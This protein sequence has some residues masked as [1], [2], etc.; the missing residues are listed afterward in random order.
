LATQGSVSSLGI[1]SL[2]VVRGGYG[3]YGTVPDGIR[4]LLSSL[5]PL[6]HLTPT[7]R[8]LEIAC[9]SLTPEMYTSIRSNVTGVH[10]L[11]FGGCLDR[12]LEDIWSFGPTNQWAVNTNLTHLRLIHC[13]SAYPPHIPELVRHFSSLRHLLVT[14]CGDFGDVRTVPQ[15]DGW[16]REPNALWRQRP[17]LDVFHIEHMLEWEILAMGTIP[18]KT[19][20]AT[21]IR[22]GELGRSFITDPDIFPGLTLLRIED[23]YLD[24]MSGDDVYWKEKFLQTRGVAVKQ[25]AKWLVTRL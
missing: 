17:P 18:T 23:T 3:P 10:S 1:G 13:Q 2:R 22:P 25:D 9:E 8:H 5:I 14:T 7:I 20:I 24:G 12:K 4:T 16:S 19:V 11:T 15:R 21:S 6:L